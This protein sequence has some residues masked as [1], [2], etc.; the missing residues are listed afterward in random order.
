MVFGLHKEPENK[1][2]NIKGGKKN[3]EQVLSTDVF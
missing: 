3:P 1:L 2:R